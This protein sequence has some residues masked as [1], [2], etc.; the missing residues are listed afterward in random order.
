MT[1]CNPGP[2]ACATCKDAEAL[3]QQVERLVEQRKQLRSIRNATHDPFILR[4]PFELTSRIFLFCSPSEERR[5]SL[6]GQD[7]I[8]LILSWVCEGE[9][10]PDVQP[11]C[12]LF[13]L[14][15]LGWRA[16]AQSTPQLWTA[17]RVALNTPGIRRSQF[18]MAE[19]FLKNSGHL[20]LRIDVFI[21]NG[22]Y[23]SMAPL[24]CEQII[25][26]LN[27]HSGRWR[28]RLEA[29]LPRSLVSQLT[30]AI[31][32]SHSQLEVLILSGFADSM[33]DMDD[34]FEQPVL[35][36]LWK[37]KGNRPSPL[38]VNIT[39]FHLRCI[40]MDWNNITEATFRS[41][42]TN[43]CLELFRRAPRVTA[44]T[45]DVTAGY[46]DGLPQHACLVPTLSSLKTLNIRFSPNIPESLVMDQLY[47]PAL[48][49]I[50]VSGSGP[51]DYVE[52]LI[53]RSKYQL[54]SLDFGGEGYDIVDRLD[55]SSLA[56]KTPRLKS[57]SVYNLS[58]S[59]LRTVFEL[60]APLGHLS[61]AEALYVVVLEKA[62]LVQGGDHLDTLK[63]MMNLAETYLF[64]SRWKEAESL[65]VVVVEKSKRMLGDDHPDT[66]VTMANL[67]STYRDQGRLKD[68]EALQVMVAEKRKRLLGED[69]PSTLTVMSNLAQ[70]F[71][72]QSRL[73]D[74]EALLLAVVEKWKQKKEDD[75]PFTL[76]S[77]S[78]LAVTYWK[79]GRWKDA[80]LLQIVTIEKMKTV[81]G[82]DHLWT[83]DNMENLANTYKDQG[84]L[85]DAEALCVEVIEK[86]KRMNGGG[87]PR[88]L[89]AMKNLAATYRALGRLNDAEALE[90]VLEKNMK[91]RE[92]LEAGKA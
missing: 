78:H 21:A 83:L 42:Y 56:R 58:S 40:D 79:Q 87:R 85:K 75:H 18:N 54:S 62:K 19:I 25:Q 30:G 46:D 26:L 6:S 70:T 22:H 32:N 12:C 82:D 74:A 41:L 8:E 13:L 47:A 68:A 84:R 17:I 77:M 65:F 3:D 72:E 88:T 14:C 89:V 52:R 92:E 1:N 91:R 44:C 15:T 36:P 33:D 28:H 20:S 69:H 67:A 10:T 9:Y 48:T 5:I 4:F 16:I 31:G 55:I 2:L 45:I 66:L 11:L 38:R 24:Y 53:D 71:R 90:A 64:Q 43:E 81:L 49:H 73:D 86:M 59:N 57:L 37:M 27:A 23:Q 35:G 7:R 51:Y 60:L 50:S 80:E 29:S 61:D 39:E 76:R 34:E 63:T